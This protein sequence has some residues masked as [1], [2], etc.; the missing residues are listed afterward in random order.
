MTNLDLI[1]MF[2]AR[3]LGRLETLA[4]LGHLLVPPKIIE[5]NPTEWT[6]PLLALALL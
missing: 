3:G 6:A 1:H 5:V 4:E 2:G